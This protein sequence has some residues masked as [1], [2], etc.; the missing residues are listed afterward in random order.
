M[1]E[2]TIARA[3]AGLAA[4]GMLLV[5]AGCLLMPGKFTSSLDLRRDGTFA[6]AYAGEIHVLALSDLARQNQTFRPHPCY[7]D[8]GMEERPCTKAETAQQK[9]DWDEA[10][11]RGADKRKRDAD[12]MKAFLGGIDPGD[13]KAAEELA[14]RLRRQAG[15][16]N[17]VSR[18]NGRFDVEFAI[19]GR[20]DHD[21]AFPTI[22]RFPYANA[23]VQIAVRNDGTVRVDAPGFGPP[24]GS[25]ALGGMM[26]GGATGMGGEDAPD[27]PRIDGAFTIRTDGAIL[28]NNTDE[29]PRPDASGQKLDWRILPQGAAAPMALVRLK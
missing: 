2:R 24:G 9:K 8:D 25:E 13:P 5:L 23:F 21:F 22:E 1:R 4:A 6:F 17:V 14:Q 15:W 20:L 16:K 18:G 11:A 10:Q 27:M 3:C 28:A 7:N 26:M 19:A 29:G 12:S